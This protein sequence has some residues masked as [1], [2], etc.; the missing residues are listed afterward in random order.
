MNTK[1][2]ALYG[3]KYNPF[4]PD[5]PTE[6]LHIYPKLDNFCLRIEHTLIQEALHP[7]DCTEL[8][9]K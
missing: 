2:L 6:A 4:T 1:L 7:V 9:E 3:L 8:S 5:V